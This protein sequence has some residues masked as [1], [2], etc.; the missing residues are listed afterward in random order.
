MD[1]RDQ[2]VTRVI[3]DRKGS[4]G[5]ME[6]TVLMVLMARRDQQDRKDLLV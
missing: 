5:L 3:R 2:K 1:L 6:R 4:Q